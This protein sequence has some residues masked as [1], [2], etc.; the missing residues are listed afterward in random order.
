MM[1]FDY[2]QFT[3]NMNEVDKVT[4]DFDHGLKSIG[5]MSGYGYIYAGR[6]DPRN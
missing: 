3:Y 4:L 6:G 2:S 5:K 1:L